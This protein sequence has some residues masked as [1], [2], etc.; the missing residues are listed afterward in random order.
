MLS[1]PFATLGVPLTALYL[2]VLDRYE[3]VMALLHP[4]RHSNKSEKSQQFAE[5]NRVLIEQAY[6]QLQDQTSRDRALE[7]LR[8]C[9]TKTKPNPQSAFARAL[10]NYPT[11]AVTAFYEGAV[12]DL[13]L[14][15]YY[16]LNNIEPVT[17]T[18]RELNL[19]YAYIKTESNEGGQ[20][21]RVP[22]SPRPDLPDFGA[23]AQ[24]DPGFATIP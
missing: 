6:V 2:E 13:K 19:V 16:S 17:Q 12:D 1:D 18:L 14:L 4:D 3:A 11:L 23:E 20:S 8:E 15:Q 7:Q 9:V 21:V 24:P 5:S 10:L 22:R